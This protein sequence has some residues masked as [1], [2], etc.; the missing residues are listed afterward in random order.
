MAISLCG[1]GLI[2][3]PSPVAILGKGFVITFFGK[4]LVVALLD[5]CSLLGIF[6]LYMLSSAYLL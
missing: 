6:L 1:K 4:R 3:I 5:K 2:I